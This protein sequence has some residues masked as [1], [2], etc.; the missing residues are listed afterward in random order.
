MKL[1]MVENVIARALRTKVYPPIIY[2]IY[3]LKADLSHQF[4]SES[5]EEID[6]VLVV[7]FSRRANILG[8]PK[9]KS[10]QTKWDRGSTF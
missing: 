6:N 4:K 7:Y 3:H 2:N 9:V 1:E 8:I 5:G 10:G